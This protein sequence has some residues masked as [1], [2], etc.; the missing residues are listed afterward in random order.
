MPSLGDLFVTVGVELGNFKA[1]MGDVNDSLKRTTREANAASAGWAAAF[2]K[3]QSV[4][5]GMSAAIT[6]PLVGLATI[7]TSEFN[8]FELAIRQVTSLL[9]NVSEGEFKQLLNATKELAQSLGIDAVKAANAL[10]EAISAGVPKENAL[11]FV[12]VSSVAAIAGLTDTKVAVDALTTIIAA[13]GLKASDAKAISDTMFQAVNVGKFQFQDLAAAIGPAAQQAN[14]LGISYTELL[15]ATS[16]LSL[17]SGGVSNAVTQIESAMRALLDPSK[18]MA[19]ALA[20]IGFN[21]G[22]AAVKALGF[23]GTLE[24][25]RK[26]NGGNAEAFN[27][28]FGRIE[29]FT[30]GLGLTGEKAGKAAED[31]EKMKH[32]TDGLGASTIAFNEINKTASRELERLQSS[33]KILGI[34][35]GQE[36]APATRKVV[37]S[38]QF[39]IQWARDAVKQF[40]DLP[41]PIQTTTLV[42]GGLAAATGPLIVGL[43]TLGFSIIQITTA[44]KLMGLT[45]AGLMTSIPWIALAAA[46]GTVALAFYNLKTA[47]D[48][49]NSTLK[50]RGAS[51]HALEDRLI[52]QG[53][54]ISEL[55]QRYALGQITIKEYSQELKNL[56]K[57]HGNTIPQVKTLTEAEKVVAAGRTSLTEVTRKATLAEL[58]K[59]EA[60]TRGNAAVSKSVATIR[61]WLDA[62]KAWGTKLEYLS[63]LVKA[64]GADLSQMSIASQA[65]A[66]HILNLGAAF[67][68]MISG[69]NNATAAIKLF[70]MSAEQIR[71]LE[72]VAAFNTLGIKS[73]ADLR[74]EA[75]LLGEAY[76]RIVELNKENKATALDVAAAHEKWSDAERKAAGISTT[77]NQERKRGLQEIST[78]INDFARSASRGIMDLFSGKFNAKLRE[79]TDG[80]KTQLADSAKDW[81]K[82]QEDISGKLSKIQEDLETKLSD[83]NFTAQRRIEDE[84]KDFARDIEKLGEVKAELVER[85]SDLNQSAQR[86]I[87]DESEDFSRDVEKSVERLGRIKFELEETLADL[88]Q[89]ASRRLEDENTDFARDVEKLRQIKEDLASVLGTLNQSSQRKTED[90]NT[91]FARDTE[92]LNIALADAQKKR[93]KVRVAEIQRELRDRTA[94]HATTLR[95]IKEDLD[96]ATAEATR[97]AAEETAQNKRELDQ[98]TADHATSLRRIQEDLSEATGEA[99]SKA[100]R[101]TAELKLEMDRRAADHAASLLRISADLDEATGEAQK[102]AAQE[103]AEGKL[104]LA[105]RTADHAAALQRI[106]EDLEKATGDA[107]TLAATQTADLKKE[108]DLRAIDYAAHTAELTKKMEDAGSQMQN[109]WEKLGGLAT[110]V[111]DSIGEAITRSIITKVIEA[112]G[113]VTK[114]GTVLGKIPGLGKIFG[115]ATEDTTTVLSGI[116]GTGIGVGAEAAG[117]AASAGGGAASA[118]STAAST[119][120]SSVLGI[121]TGAA[122]A[123]SGII[124]NFQ[125]M[126]MNKSLDIIV[127]HTL[128]TANDLANLRADEWLRETHLMVK[129]DDL[130][131]RMAELLGGW[132]EFQMVKLD[133]LHNRMATQLS[134]WRDALTFQLGDWRTYL[135]AQMVDV[136][137]N[138]AQLTPATAGAGAAAGG[139]TII[140]N[141][142]N[143][144]MFVSDRAIDELLDLLV[145][146]LKQRN[147]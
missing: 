90:E 13:Y 122:S 60:L 64:L 50:D 33:A 146:R 23:E 10:Y 25:L 86:R 61:E 126:G 39:L 93:D 107:R 136:I 134:G 77:T 128:Q 70:T 80:I 135:Q 27:A 5:L 85:L 57:A 12:R 105:R 2:G 99:K 26:T 42:L 11:D 36:L 98:R 53:V 140:N 16:T 88:N 79:V 96:R 19:A 143:G 124:G 65:T 49:L 120:L 59:A 28:L 119:S 58:L 72:G 117:G 35:I 15:A 20:A 76:Q 81:S 112:T 87:D 32:A 45:M 113:I 138:T 14:N 18:Q 102:K 24:A 100:A 118:A 142:I 75:D 56:A 69:A 29:G 83:L 97:R 78:I 125:S 144:G 31:L 30:A 141:N 44:A 139:G 114:L 67:D 89:T 104:E 145:N 1:A 21:T 130:H 48:N 3:M 38:G 71:D 137:H 115:G 129:L 94:D 55:S 47:Q 108:L 82:Y 127:K 46:A 95:R 22:S 103:T 4:G 84:N 91:D 92:K 9:G 66:T 133:D 34:E 111:L 132:R 41:V 63:P 62:G 40:G 110:G 106:Q 68:P 147:A 54:N 17:T 74:R 8:K 123:V 116:G 51:L 52:K 121:I 7:A 109:I 73:T 37:D 43:G 101:E 6:A 131:N